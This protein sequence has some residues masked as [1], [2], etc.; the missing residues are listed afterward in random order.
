MN[1]N[2]DIKHQISCQGWSFGRVK[3][4]IN[5]DMKIYEETARNVYHRGT[6][7]KITQTALKIKC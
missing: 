7:I 2:L 5:V 6:F 3:Q 1:A 4:I